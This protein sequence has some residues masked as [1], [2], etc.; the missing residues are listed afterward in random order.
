MPKITLNFFGE[1]IN[2]DIPKTISSL[3]SEI[4]KLFFFSPQ[5]A[6]EI[7][8]TYKINGEK[9]IIAND[10]DLKTFLNSKS[11]MIDLDISQTSKI[12][13]DSFNKLQEENSKDKNILKELIN[14]NE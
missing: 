12:Y 11:K 6:A 14:K 2:S 3:R 9:K 10:Q 5:D 13:K 7:L 8:L 1:T 4:S